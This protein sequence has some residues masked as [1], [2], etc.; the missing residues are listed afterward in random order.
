MTITPEKGQVLVPTEGQGLNLINLFQTI[1]AMSPGYW[2]AAETESR[3]GFA[4]VLVALIEGFCINGVF[5][6]IGCILIRLVR[7]EL[8][9]DIAKAVSQRWWFSKFPP[10]DFQDLV[11]HAFTYFFS[12][13]VALWLVW[14]GPVRAMEIEASAWMEIAIRFGIA[15]IVLVVTGLVTSYGMLFLWG[16]IPFKFGTT[17]NGSSKLSKPVEVAMCNLLLGIGMLWIAIITYLPTW[18]LW[19]L[20]GAPVPARPV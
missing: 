7:L 17:E 11:N 6:W 15:G 9:E 2:I 4:G 16:A 5:S 14:N 10:C 19:W 13:I 8:P 3:I 20:V 12:P 1:V 18:V